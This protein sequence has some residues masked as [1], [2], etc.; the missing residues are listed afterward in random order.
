MVLFDWERA[1]DKVIHA[2]LFQALERVNFPAQMIDIVKQLYKQPV[3]R[4]EFE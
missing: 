3:F 2:E 4:I 1:F